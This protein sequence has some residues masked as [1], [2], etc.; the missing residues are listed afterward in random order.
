MNATSDRAPGPIR[1][2][3]LRIAWSV[4]WGSLCLLMITWW[5]RSYRWQDGGFVKLTGQMPF[6]LLSA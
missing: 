3:K 2:R 6:A 1:F 5:A 4:F